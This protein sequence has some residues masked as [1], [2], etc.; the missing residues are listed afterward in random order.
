MKTPKRTYTTCFLEW[1]DEFAGRL[2]SGQQRAYARWKRKNRIARL[3][4]KIARLTAENKWLAEER[5]TYIN[6]YFDTLAD[7]VRAYEQL[8]IKEQK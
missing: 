5:L 8:K 2:S 3:K 7:L 4:D 1:G 6:R